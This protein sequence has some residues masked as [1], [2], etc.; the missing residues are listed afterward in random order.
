MAQIQQVLELAKRHFSNRP[1]LRTDIVQSMTDMGAQIINYGCWCFFDGD[2][3]HAGGEAQDHFDMV[4][5]ELHH[6]YQ[7]IMDDLGD[8][9]PQP[10]MAEFVVPDLFSGDFSDEDVSK[11]L[12][13]AMNPGNECNQLACQVEMGFIDYVIQAVFVDHEPISPDLAHGNAFDHENVCIKATAEPFANGAGG[14]D[15]AKCCGRYPHRFPY[16]R[17]L[18]SCSADGSTLLALGN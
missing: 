6:G 3:H 2:H 12:C 9:C 4:C 18:N 11:S 17:V 15:H 13:A 5:K 8:Q 16:N 14:R 1:G 10:W 7:C